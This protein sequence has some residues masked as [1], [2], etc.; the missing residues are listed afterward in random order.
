VVVVAFFLNFMLL[1][2]QSCFFFFFFSKGRAGEYKATENVEAI[3]DC[4]RWKA[5][6]RKK[7]RGEVFV[8]S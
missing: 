1:S 8:F 7:E 6:R 3:L 4:E 2:L 5:R